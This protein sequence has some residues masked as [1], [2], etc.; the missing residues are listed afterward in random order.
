M[1]REKVSGKN[2]RTLCRLSAHFP[3]AKRRHV[4]G[5]CLKLCSEQGSILAKSCFSAVELSKALLSVTYGVE[6]WAYF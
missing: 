4:G 2:A 1:G 5:V 6:L 3:K